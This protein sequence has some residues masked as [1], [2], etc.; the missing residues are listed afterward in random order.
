MYVKFKDENRAG[1]ESIKKMETIS[2]NMDLR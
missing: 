1:N 2:C